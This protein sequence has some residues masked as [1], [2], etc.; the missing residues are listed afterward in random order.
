M[1]STPYA[2]FKTD[3][4]ILRDCLAADRTVLANERTLLSYVRTAMAF[5]AAGAALLRFHIR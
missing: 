1:K 3:E 2:R 4:L 5:M